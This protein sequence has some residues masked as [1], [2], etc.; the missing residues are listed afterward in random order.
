MNFLAHV[1]LSGE[2]LDIAIGNLI[3][4]QVKGKEIE[5]Y[6]KGI[7][8]GIILHRSIDKY[9]DTHPIVR[10]CRKVL[11]SEYR[12]YSGVIVDMYFDHF[13]ALHWK[14]FHPVPL[15]DF[16]STFY[17]KVKERS[18]DFPYRTQQFVSSLIR[19][20][21]FSYYESLQG[22]RKILTQME[23]RI[24][25]PSKLSSSV[26]FL[27]ENYNYFGDHFFHFMEDVIPFSK[28]QYLIIKSQV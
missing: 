21:W 27:E 28:N 22:L 11:F 2:N 12:H 24:K 19:Y 20:D 26:D 4:D 23:Q 17:S 5:F 1:F 25:N 13:L 15:F 3:A 14:R 10:E 18:V 16:S 6:P 7:Q 9:T 8:S